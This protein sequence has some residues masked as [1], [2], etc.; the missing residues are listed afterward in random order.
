MN[1]H[2]AGMSHKAEI[3]RAIPAP[4]DLK[5]FAAHYLMARFDVSPSLANTI[6][7]LAMLGGAK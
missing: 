3:S 2:T 7:T 1:V 5:S 4:D 6:A